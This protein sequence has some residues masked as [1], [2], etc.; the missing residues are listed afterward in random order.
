MQVIPSLRC[1]SSRPTLI[2]RVLLDVMTFIY[3]AVMENMWPTTIHRLCMIFSTTHQSPTCW[4]LILSHDMLKSSRRLPKL[5]K[6]M[7]GPS[8]TH[9]HLMMAVP[10][11][12]QMCRALKASW[13]GR[14][15]SG[16][17][18]SSPAVG[19]FRSVAARKRRIHPTLWKPQMNSLVLMWQLNYNRQKSTAGFAHIF[20]H[21]A[22]FLYLMVHSGSV[23]IQR[24]KRWHE[25]VLL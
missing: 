1:T 22:L 21:N 4:P 15:S 14:R 23:T 24:V 10:T 20:K 8:Q 16:N 18:G 11:P 17:P 19:P 2:P 7:W 5:W 6:D 3:V 13:L 9:T 25:K 12:A